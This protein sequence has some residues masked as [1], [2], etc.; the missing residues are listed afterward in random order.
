[1]VA[2][3]VM[4]MPAVGQ[5]LIAANVDSTLVLSSAVLFLGLSYGAEGD[6]IGY[7]VARSFG[8]SIYGTVLGIMAASISL[9]SAFGSV[10]LSATLKSTGG[11]GLFLVASAVL[12]IIGSLFFLLLPKPVSSNETRD[13]NIG[14]QPGF[15]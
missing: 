5:L 14:A 1:V 15:S 10:F 2:T 13:G 11:Y 8:I 6:L 12:A 7:L 9:G 4:A 3:I